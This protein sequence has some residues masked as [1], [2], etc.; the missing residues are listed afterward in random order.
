MKRNKVIVIGLDGVSF[1]ILRP[2]LNQGRLPNLQHLM[3]TGVSTPMTSVPPVHTASAWTSLMTGRRIDQHGVFDFFEMAEDEYRPR[4]LSSADVKAPYL[5]EIASQQGLRS[6]VINIPLTH[7]ARAFDGILIPGS[8]APP[9]PPCYPR[10]VLEEV[11]SAIGGYQIYWPNEVDDSARF[12]E[13]LQGFLK[14]SGMRRDAAIYLAQKYDWDLLIV[15]FQRTDSIFHILNKETSGAGSSQSMKA[16][17]RLFKT[18]DDYIGD[19]ISLDQEATIFLVSDHGMGATDWLFAINSWLKSEGYLK[20]RVDESWE[21]FEIDAEFSRLADPADTSD[22]SPVEAILKGLAYLGLTKQR[23]EKLVRFLR[24][25]RM[26]LKLVPYELLKTQAGSE[27]ID[28]NNSKAFCHYSSGGGV[29]INLKGREP[30]GS[31]FPGA[32]YESL[33]DEIVTRLSHLND[34]QGQ[35]L[36]EWVAKRAE[37]Y[38]GPYFDKIPDIVYLPRGDNYKIEKRIRGNIFI[39]IKSYYAHKRDGLFLARGGFVRADGWSPRA[40]PSI[41][42]FAKTVLCTLGLPVDLGMSGEVL[43]IFEASFLNTIPEPI[44]YTIE[45]VV[46]FDVR[47]AEAND[48]ERKM[49]EDHLRA[50]GYLD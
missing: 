7:P 28:W 47:T 4:F 42:D 32:E 43:D 45:D 23:V 49:M 9:H 26:V 46:N 29:R 3:D 18:I 24:L 44:R 13:K 17:E 30:R 8:M 50:L 36:F 5:W 12:E 31:V 34:P 10:G 40:T 20:T 21:A 39:P 41:L 22:R 2:W 38:K 25:E 37:F 6:I 35:P 27:S 11:S 48:S 1:D 15:Q 14:L 16:V 19:I 33:C